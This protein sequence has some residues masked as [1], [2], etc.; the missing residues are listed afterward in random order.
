MKLLIVTTL[1]KRPELTK[2][3]LDYYKT[4]QFKYGFQLLA[5]GS[6]DADRQLAFKCGWNYVNADNKPLAQKHNALF[7][8]A[9][10]YSH[11]AIMLIGSDDLVSEEII[12][13]YQQTF[14]HE[15]EFVVGFNTL[16]FYSIE[17]NELIYFKGYPNDHT[18][19]ITMGA[20]RLFPKWVLEKM[21][22]NLWN[23]SHL[24]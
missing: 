23:E 19:R 2:I 13:Y 18:H 15:T 7:K 22:Y 10:R 11:D 6:E 12:K 8:E 5:C 4:L 24:R 14:S 1:H 9:S 20:G 3:V 16:H 21:D 17:K